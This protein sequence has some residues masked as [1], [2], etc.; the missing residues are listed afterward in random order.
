MFWTEAVQYVINRDVA[1]SDRLTYLTYAFSGWGQALLL[2]ASIDQG[3]CFD[4]CQ[5]INVSMSV[6]PGGVSYATENLD[7]VCRMHFPHDCTVGRLHP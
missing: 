3:V 5:T 1:W 4:D 7:L 2:C 6:Y